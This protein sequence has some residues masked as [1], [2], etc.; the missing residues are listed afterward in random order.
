[1]SI[2]SRDIDQLT[3]T[4]GASVGL[5]STS[6]AFAFPR[7]RGGVAFTGLPLV[8]ESAASRTVFAARCLCGRRFGLIA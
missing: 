1:M 2:L 4:P 3:T 5:G 7:D 6:S 8:T